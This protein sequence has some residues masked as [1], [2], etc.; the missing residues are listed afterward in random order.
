MFSEVAQE[1]Q[2]LLQRAN[3]LARLTYL[4]ETT[5]GRHASTTA[6]CRSTRLQ[7]FEQPA[8]C[9]RWDQVGSE[10]P[11][12][13]RSGA[14]RSQGPPQSHGQMR[15]PGTSASD[16]IQSRTNAA[17]LQDRVAMGAQLTPNLDVGP[18][19]GPFSQ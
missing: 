14:R 3:S 9:P 8:P 10:P 16:R 12:R 19:M 2:G 18:E 4:P 5:E 11:W 7:V 15:R 13:P 1:H 17:A 6:G